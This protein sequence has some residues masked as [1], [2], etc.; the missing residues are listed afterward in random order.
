LTFLTF[1]TKKL[2]KDTLRAISQ[3][4]DSIR[5]VGHD[6]REYA[7]VSGKE[8]PDSGTFVDVTVKI[9]GVVT[10]VARYALVLIR[11]SRQ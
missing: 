4:G 2:A 1:D 5:F 10:A 6:G 7:I 9:D 8:I 3:F 11:I